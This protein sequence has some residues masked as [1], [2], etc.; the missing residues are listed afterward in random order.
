VLTQ[1]C[2]SRRPGLSH[3][4]W[5]TAG[6]RLTTFAELG[7][8]PAQRRRL[9]ELNKEWA[10][11]I[12]GRGPFHSCEEYERELRSFGPRGVAL[13]LAGDEWVGM[14]AISDRRG[15]GCVFNEMTG[16]SCVPGRRRGRRHEGARDG[17]RGVWGCAG[18]T[19][20]APWHHAACGMHLA[21]TVHHAANTKVIAMNRMLGYV[22][23]DWDEFTA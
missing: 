19:S 2:C 9:Y 21:R 5:T 6:V 3:V 8:G 22:D 23:A 20:H 10:A 7:D 18:C 16:A 11:D 14:A 12:P 17:L 1:P 15:S 13:A 4:T